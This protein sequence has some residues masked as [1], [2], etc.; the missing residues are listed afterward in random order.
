MNVVSVSQ[1]DREGHG[2]LFERGIVSIKKLSEAKF[3]PIGTIR[4]DLYELS[5]PEIISS[6]KQKSWMKSLWHQR[7]GHANERIVAETINY[8]AV[9]GVNTTDPGRK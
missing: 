1:L 3:K 6:M 2:I 5:G 7:L 8:G 9:D 4:D